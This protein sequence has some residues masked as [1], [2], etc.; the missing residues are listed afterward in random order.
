MGTLEGTLAKHGGGKIKTGKVK[1]SVSSSYF[2]Y[3]NGESTARHYIQLVDL[4]FKP[5]LVQAYK[6]ASGTRNISTLTNEP[7]IDAQPIIITS[8]FGT[9][10]NTNVG[11]L[12][13]NDMVFVNDRIVNIPIGDGNMEYFYIAIG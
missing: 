11:L 13:A 3:L 9:S 8:T 7:D 5:R 4:G 12:K 6:L 10:S 2:T 1:S